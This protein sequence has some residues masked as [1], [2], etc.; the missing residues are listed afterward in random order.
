MQADSRSIILSDKCNIDTI[1]QDHFAT[2]SDCPAIASKRLNPEI[3]LFASYGDVLTQPGP[4]FT[5]YPV[6]RL[7][8]NWDQLGIDEM[9]A[10]LRDYGAICGRS[11]T[12]IKTGF[13]G[14]SM[15]DPG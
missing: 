5:G 14:E 6:I 8:D 3:G 11:Q 9:A 10:A 7:S 13:I 1:S 2:G 4:D 15:T 12:V